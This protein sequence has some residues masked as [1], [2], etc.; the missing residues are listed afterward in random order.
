MQR[1]IMT[2]INTSGILL[3]LHYI[4]TVYVTKQQYFITNML[5]Y[6][7]YMI[8]PLYYGAC[9]DNRVASLRFFCLEMPARK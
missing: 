1:F 2:T 6:Y 5:Q 4:L 3:S 8:H 9:I 7:M